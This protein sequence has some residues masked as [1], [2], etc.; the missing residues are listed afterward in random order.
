MYT[1]QDSQND[2]FSV[3]V[4]KKYVYIF[5]LFEN[6]NNNKNH[7]PNTMAAISSA[8]NRKRYIEFFMH[9]TSGGII[10]KENGLL[11]IVK[12]S[13]LEARELDFTCLT[14]KRYQLDNCEKSFSYTSVYE[15]MIWAVTNVFGTSFGERADQVNVANT[16]ELQFGEF[17]DWANRAGEMF[18]VGFYSKHDECVDRLRVLSENTRDTEYSAQ[19]SEKRDEILR[20]GSPLT[21][22]TVRAFS[23]YILALEKLHSLSRQLLTV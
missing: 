9:H 8:E 16:M 13:D 12:A 18:P 7:F 1:I 15:L 14:L 21:D 17:L 23:K 22:K 11:R 3:R 10:N 2:L 20:R 5:P 6:N 19:V 4:A